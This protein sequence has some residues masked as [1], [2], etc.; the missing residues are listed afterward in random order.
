MH[1]SDPTIRPAREQDSEAILDMIKGLAFFEK[2]PEKVELDVETLK[3]DG[4]GLQPSFKAFV[5]EAEG[6]LLGF[7]LSYT[8]YSTWRGR[9]CF[10]ED[11]FV[12]EE[13]RGKG[14]GKKLLDV[15]IN[16]ALEQ[17]MKYTCLQVLDWN[18]PAI[19]FYRKYPGST[20]DPEWINVLL[21]NQVDPAIEQP[22]RERG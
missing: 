1:L 17:G 15:Q 20:F 5:A 21:P 11:L 13:F 3:K 22:S 19:S 7:S 14:I 18:E 8:R 12:R 4:F 10:V 2:A 16:W 9:V 6:T